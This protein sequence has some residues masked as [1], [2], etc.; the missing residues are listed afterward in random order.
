MPI[1]FQLKRRQFLLTGGAALAGAAL[2][3][4]N[5][6]SAVAGGRLVYAGFGGSYE[7]AVRLALFDPYTKA[8]D[9]EVVMTTGGS[10]VARIRAMVRAGRPQWD[11]IDAQGATLGQFINDGL[12]QP[13]DAK[14]T[15]TEDIFD[16]A[17]IT[18]FSVPW[19]QFS[20]N[21]FWNTTAV[22]GE[23]ASWADVW[24]VAKFPGKRGLSKLPWFSL[25]I[26][27]LADGVPLDKLYP[28]DV[29]RAFASLDR[30][31]PHAVFLDTNS[32]ANA[33]SSQEIT[34]GIISLA[35]IKAIQQAGVKLQYS[36]QQALT[37]V[38][39][40]VVLKGAPDAANA[41]SAIGFALHPDRQLALLD[42]I[43]CTPTTRTALAKIPPER[44]RDLAG[45]D[46]TRKTSFYLNADWWGK[47]GLEVGRRWQDWLAG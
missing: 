10:D 3:G 42:Q 4:F 30:I 40:L 24:N 22:K 32:L 46:F 15:G 8:A 44:A 1:S 39:Q 12:L 21:L 25:E 35:R 7:R 31:R 6:P 11:L 36:W 14:L 27:L 16:R 28:L 18:P 13:L 38:Q 9:V 2:E 43:G 33:I 34:M 20:L 23:P 17:R 5:I 29:D 47:H 45:T 41:L 19:Y 37:D 26:A